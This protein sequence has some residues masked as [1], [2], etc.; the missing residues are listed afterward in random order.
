[1]DRALLEKHLAMAE[2]NVR[3]GAEH[4]E[5]QR[6]L[7]ARRESLGRPSP[8]ACELL[9]M[10]EEL[11]VEHVAHRDRLLHDLRVGS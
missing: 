3:R 8:T 9:E 2:R 1:M 7:V 6:A 10:F 5:R 4:L 11:Q